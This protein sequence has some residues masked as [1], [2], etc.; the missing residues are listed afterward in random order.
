VLLVCGY[1]DPDAQAEPHRRFMIAAF[2]TSTVF[3]ACY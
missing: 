2:A 3:L 1:S